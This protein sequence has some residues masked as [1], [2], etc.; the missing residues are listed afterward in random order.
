[1]N[2]KISTQISKYWIGLNKEK[3]HMCPSIT[4]F[5]IVS[6]NKIKIFNKKVLDIGFGEGQNLIECK[7]RG[8]DVFGI[9]LRKKKIEDIATNYRIS[10]KKLFQCDLNKNFPLINHKFKLI[11]SLDTINYITFENQLKLFDNI[12]ELLSNDGYFL[13]QYP[14]TQ[15]KLK[16]KKKFLDYWIDKKIYLVQDKFYPYANPVMFLP[17]KQINDLIKL[18]KKKFKLLSSIFDIGTFSKS[19]S[20]SLTINRFLLLKKNSLFPNK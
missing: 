16:K 4:F 6:Q 10:K 15:L 1:M 7:K 14:Q 20:S 8:A 2:N 5:R 12:Y 19:D 3:L 11:F 18:N 13:F 17:N 9:E